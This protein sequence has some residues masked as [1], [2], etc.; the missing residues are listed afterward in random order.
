MSDDR[1][2]DEQSAE[3][4]AARLAELLRDGEL[5][6]AVAESLTGGSL[7]ADLAAA[8]DSSTWYRGGVVAYSS[9]VKHDLLDVPP[10]PVVSEPS[11]AAMAE[12]V[13]RLLGAD[14]SLSVTGV[15][16]PDPQDDQ[17]PG[18]VWMGLHDR[19]AGTTGTE[20]H[21]FEGS[22]DEIVAATRHGALAWL[23]GRCD[24]RARDEADATT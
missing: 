6:I 19:R 1:P 21:H 18:T 14:L 8:E 22:P 3:E 13:A 23:L 10:G 16:G 11:A 20:L 7:S 2:S 17:P 4:L 12:G 9:E 5:T 15:G 24:A